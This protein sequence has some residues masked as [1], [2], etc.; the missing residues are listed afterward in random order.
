[1]T[2]TKGAIIRVVEML[3]DDS[4]NFVLDWLKQNFNTSPTIV[5]W[6]SI[7][8]IEP[9]EDDLDM[10]AEIEKN[11]DCHIFMSERELDSG[12]NMHKSAV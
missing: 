4:A 5:D 7:E 10:L 11:P 9:D 1:M 8:E 2:A 12:R 6:D 3:N